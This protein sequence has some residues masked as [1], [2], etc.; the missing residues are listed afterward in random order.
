[1]DLP[2]R[3]LIVRHPRRLRDTRLIDWD[4]PELI[5]GYG[6]SPLEWR[7]RELVWWVV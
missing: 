2:A 7:A 6:P 4:L 3:L 5:A 1:M